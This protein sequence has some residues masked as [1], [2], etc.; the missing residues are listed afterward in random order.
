VDIA[1]HDEFTTHEIISEADL[2][3]IHRRSIHL[4][5]EENAHPFWLASC[6]SQSQLCGDVSHLQLLA[7]RGGDELADLI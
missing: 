2:H 5:M 6:E 7:G 4:L 3:I 1:N